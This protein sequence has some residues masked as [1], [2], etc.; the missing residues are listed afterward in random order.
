MRSP[1]NN[2]ARL[3][4]KILIM[5]YVFRSLPYLYLEALLNNGSTQS[6]IAKRYKTTEGNLVHWL[7][8]HNLTRKKN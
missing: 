3:K 5:T 1:I 2:P 7:K 4:N 8:Q 6:F